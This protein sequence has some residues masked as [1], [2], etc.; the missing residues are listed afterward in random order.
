M[1]EILIIGYTTNIIFIFV[2]HGSKLCLVTMIVY[3]QI[4]KVCTSYVRLCNK[5][6]S[7]IM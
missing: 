7:I 6:I 2:L 1:C 3:Y 5:N 4:R